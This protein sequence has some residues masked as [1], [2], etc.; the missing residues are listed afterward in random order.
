[1]ANLSIDGLDDLLK[2]LTALGSLPDVVAEETMNAGADVIVCVQRDEIRKQ[3]SGPYSE[4]ISSQCIKKGK[5][6]KTKDGHKILISPRDTRRRGR[7]TV[8]NAE[9]AFL[10]EYGSSGKG[11]DKS[12]KKRSDPKR[13]L[14]RPAIRIANEK[15]ESSVIQA[16]EKVRD[17]YLD[18]HGL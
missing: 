15:A 4:G 13:I 2:D 18:K 3:W 14:P 11:R 8:R 12:H 16:M 6:T 5:V 1:M 7:H 9:I 17:T 10:N